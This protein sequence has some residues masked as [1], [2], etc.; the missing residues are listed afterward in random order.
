MSFN[1]D[2]LATH[3]TFVED[4]LQH[5]RS[6]PLPPDKGDSDLS[7][8]AR[9]IT[10]VADAK[11][12]GISIPLPPSRGPSGGIFGWFEEAAANIVAL[13]LGGI[14]WIFALERLSHGWRAVWMEI[15][16][17]R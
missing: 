16:A 3:L 14:G 13:I 12:R 17:R 5:G 8:L 11:Q 2:D 7:D 15:S 6:I 9:H 1:L 4:G 10:F